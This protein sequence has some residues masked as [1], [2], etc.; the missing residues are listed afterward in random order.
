MDR[1]LRLRLP[2]ALIPRARAVSLRLPGQSQRTHRD[3]QGRLLTDA[4]MTSISLEEHFTDDFLTNMLPILRHRSALGLWQ[5]AIAATSTRPELDILRR[6]DEARDHNP[7]SDGPLSVEELAA[8]R[9]L[10]LVAE[11]LDEDVSWHSPA[12]FQAAANIAHDLL[13]GDQ[14]DA[15]EQFLYEQDTKWGNLRWDLRLG[16][17]AREQYRR[18]LNRYDWAGRGGTAVWRAERTVEI[19]DFEDWLTSEPRADPVERVVRPPGWQLRLPATW[20]ALDV[21]T[22]SEEVPEP[23]TKW[24][25]EGRVLAFPHQHRQAVWPLIPSRTRTGW[26]PVADIAPIIRAGRRLRADQVV[27]FIESLLIDWSDEHLESHV[28]ITLNLPAG[29]AFEFG[30]ITKEEQQNAVA[31]AR[32]TTSLM[33]DEIINRLPE[34]KN[35][36]RP[37]LEQAKGSS[38]QFTRIARLIPIKFSAT[39]ATWRWPGRTVVDELHKGTPPDVAEWLATFAYR[40]SSLILGNSMEAAWH[41][42]FDRFRD[43]V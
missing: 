10:L 19:E 28:R 23:Y 26:Q 42:A 30:L 29:K 33:M 37:D 4:V 12:R 16:G 15:N 7:E 43:L 41:E 34:G 20:R 13:I 3:Y 14:V 5:L 9:R 31:R 21:A 32:Q 11:I 40:T 17:R 36:L 6:A 18:G 35:Y 27:D 1:P 39:R 38:Q 24:I 8:Q 22:A 25:T 2:L